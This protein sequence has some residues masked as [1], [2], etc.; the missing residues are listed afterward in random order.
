MIKHLNGFSKLYRLKSKIAIDILFEKNN[1]ENQSF[2]IYP[3]KVIINVTKEKLNN[4]VKVLVSVSSRRFKKAV[5]RNVIKRRIRESYRKNKVE[6][7]TDLNVALIYVAKDIL[8]YSQIEKSIVK[9]VKRLNS[10]NE[11]P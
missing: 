9:I 6:V 5:D 11:T 8:D 10:F 4:P 1:E 3:I 2:L 7:V